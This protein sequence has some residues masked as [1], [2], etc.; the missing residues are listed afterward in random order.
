V[1]SS[2]FFLSTLKNF[3]FASCCCFCFST[4]NRISYK[5][6]F[7]DFVFVF[8][9]A[10]VR[11]CVRACVCVSSFMSPQHPTNLN[12]IFW[13]RTKEDRCRSGSICSYFD[14]LPATGYGQTA[15][16]PLC[17]NLYV[18]VTNGH[19]LTSFDTPAVDSST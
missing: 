6:N 9:R 14:S 18:S 11:A 15:H 7:I 8:V 13:E 3:I 19:F 12:N 5:R 17:P 2:W 10:F 4:S 1:T 16:C